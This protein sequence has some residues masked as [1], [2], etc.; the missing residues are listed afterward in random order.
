[1]AA[2]GTVRKTMEH[3]STTPCASSQDSTPGVRAARR[4]AEARLRLAT[5]RTGYPRC[6]KAAARA[7]ATAPAPMNPMPPSVSVGAGWVIAAVR[8]GARGDGGRCAG[9]IENAFVE[10]STRAQGQAVYSPSRSLVIPAALGVTCGRRLAATRVGSGTI[11]A[12]RPG[13]SRE[14]VAVTD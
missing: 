6:E 3:R 2:S 8:G 4:R 12:A 1:M 13:V 9:W 11:L 10:A 5:A 14:S 7:V